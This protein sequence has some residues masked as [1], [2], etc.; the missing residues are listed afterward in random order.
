MN[1]EAEGIIEGQYSGFNSIPR[2]AIVLP[3]HFEHLMNSLRCTIAAWLILVVSGFQSVDAGQM[4][5]DPSLPPVRGLIEAYREDAGVLQR[6][7]PWSMSVVRHERMK[8]LHASFREALE[9]IPYDALSQEEKIDYLMFQ[10]QLVFDG[11]Q[12]DRLRDRHLEIAPWV[13]FGQVIL[14]LFEARQRVEPVQPESMATTLDQLKLTVQNHR[15]ELK[16]L[17]ESE[18]DLIRPTLAGRIGQWVDTYQNA[19]RDWYRFYEGYH[20]SF[21]WWMKTPY[22]SVDKE[23]KRFA[24]FVRQ[25]IAGFVEGEDPPLLGDPIGKD[26][27]MEALNMR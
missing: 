11:R 26:A 21:S 4:D 23:L 19:L 17:L 12:L 18:P 10:N 25:E 9:A 3:M 16:T 8:A 14:D 2:L 5:L 6:F 22:E 7:H 24:E 1:N 15:K 20:P 13:P 27:L